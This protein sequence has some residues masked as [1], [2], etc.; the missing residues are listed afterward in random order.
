MRLC[1]QGGARAALLAA[2]S[3]AGAQAS[4]AVRPYPLAPPAG[5]T[6]PAAP[7]RNLIVT[8]LTTLGAA[9]GTRAP[10]ALTVNGGTNMRGHLQALSATVEQNLLGERAR[11]GQWWARAKG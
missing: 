9:T 8:G 10:V 4:D 5:S 11:R 3:P 6:N 7:R 1:V 2:D